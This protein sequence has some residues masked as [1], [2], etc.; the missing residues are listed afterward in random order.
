MWRVKFQMAPIA[1]EASRVLYFPANFPGSC[2]STTRGVHKLLLELARSYSAELKS[3]LLKSVH[4][5]Y[6]TEQGSDKRCGG[7]FLPGYPGVC[8][9]LCGLQARPVQ[10]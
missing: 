8:G 2:T 4:Y 10:G 6:Q 1:S 9:N 5:V 7:Q 3:L